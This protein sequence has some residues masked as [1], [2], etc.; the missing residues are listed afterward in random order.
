VILR[1]ICVFCGSRAGNRS[2]YRAA[3]E[4]LGRLLAARGVTLVYGGGSVGL[5]G[6]VA[7]ATMAAGGRVIGVIPQALATREVAHY[8]LTDLRV[9]ASMHERKALMAELA[10]AFVAMPGGYGT[11]EEVLEI[12]TW[13]QL[14]IHAKPIGLLNVDGFFDPLLALVDHAI[15]E[16]F[17]VADNRALIQ[18]AADPADLLERLEENRPPAALPVLT[19]EET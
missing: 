12:V 4:S 19:P 11:F 3:A 9:V 5:M 14:G 18:E 1:S 8:G 16:D 13:A 10:D 6:D 2:G 17:I 15:R 7:S